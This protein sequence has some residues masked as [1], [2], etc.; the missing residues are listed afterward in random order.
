TCAGG[1]ERRLARRAARAGVPLSP[2]GAAR[3][4]GR[5]HEGGAPPVGR[6]ARV[7]DGT[8][9][10][11]I[12]CAPFHRAAVSG[13]RLGR[14]RRAA[15]RRARARPGRLRRRHGSGRVSLLSTLKIAEAAGRPEL[16]ASALHRYLAESVWFP[17]ALL[18]QSGV[19]WTPLDDRRAL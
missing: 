2:P 4:T 16:D 3:C 13:L 18:P 5:D 12:L 9:L 10:G 19:T 15:A 17:S 7:A 8:P 1:G 6:A 11:E 14:A